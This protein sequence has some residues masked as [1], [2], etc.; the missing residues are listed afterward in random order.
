MSTRPGQGPFTTFAIFALAGPW[1][2]VF[3]L[4][5]PNAINVFRWIAT[6]GTYFWLLLGSVWYVYPFG[7]WPGLIAGA[8]VVWR[9]YSAHGSTILFAAA[10]GAIGGVIWIAAFELFVFK[11]GTKYLFTE[12]NLW[13]TAIC[14]VAAMACW[15]LSRAPQPA[16]A[17]E[18]SGNSR[19]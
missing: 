18:D 17:L 2:G 14:A 19:N 10:A 7:V 3:L 5:L 9:D 15:R 13:R 16:A 12:L 1:I 11:L 6:D 4:F 8:I